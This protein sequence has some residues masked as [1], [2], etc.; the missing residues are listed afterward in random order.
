MHA[1]ALSM[2][3]ESKQT[4]KILQDQEM[5]PIADVWWRVVKQVHL[6]PG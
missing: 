5:L 4:H 2:Y 6:K 3:H 1:P